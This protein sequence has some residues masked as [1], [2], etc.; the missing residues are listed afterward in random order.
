MPACSATKGNNGASPIAVTPCSNAPTTHCAEHQ[1]LLWREPDSRRRTWRGANESSHCRFDGFSDW[2]L[3]SCDELAAFFRSNVDRH[4]HDPARFYWTLTRGT[5]RFHHVVNHAD[6]EVYVNDNDESPFYV[7][8][9][10]R[11]A[12]LCWEIVD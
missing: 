1:G 4:Q 7:V 5:N 6:A 8:L 12:P 9:V 2:R 3:P 11:L 10:R